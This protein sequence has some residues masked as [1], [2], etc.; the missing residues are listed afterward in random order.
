MALTNESKR[1][2]RKEIGEFSRR[3]NRKNK[4]IVEVTKQ[5]TRLESELQVM[6]DAKASL[7]KDLGSNGR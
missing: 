4:E 6:E 3:I 1:V 2:I 7:E 5:K